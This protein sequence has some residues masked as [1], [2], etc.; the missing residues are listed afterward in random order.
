MDQKNNTRGKFQED[1]KLLGDL[2]ALIEDQKKTAKMSPSAQMLVKRAMPG[3]GALIP[4]ARERAEH[5]IAVL[6]AAKE[7]LAELMEEAHQ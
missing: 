6:T 5:T 3:A 4:E 2:Q 7:R 1:V